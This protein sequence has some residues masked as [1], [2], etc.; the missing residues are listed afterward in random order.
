M[1]ITSRPYELASPSTSNTIDMLP[2]LELSTSH[3]NPKFAVLHKRLTNLLG[4]DGAV[5]L[6]AEESAKRTAVEEV[7]YN[8]SN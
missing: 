1:E 5:R 4:A 3:N 2:P 6:S 8:C 7:R